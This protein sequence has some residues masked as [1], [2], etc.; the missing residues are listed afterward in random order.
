MM[1]AARTPSSHQKGHRQDP[2]PLP[3]PRRTAPQ[4]LATPSTGEAELEKTV[5]GGL[6]SSQR[7]RL[8]PPPHTHTSACLHAIALGACADPR[9]PHHRR[10]GASPAAT[11]GDGGEER[12]GGGGRSGGLGFAPQSPRGDDARG[13]RCVY[14]S[15][16]FVLPFFS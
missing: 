7:R 4:P 11:S 14:F 1:S 10:C 2:W 15:Q 16:L 6:S 5:G 12:E 9:R 3:G 13:S 8:C